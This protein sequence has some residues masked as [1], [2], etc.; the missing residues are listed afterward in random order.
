MPDTPNINIQNG[1]V[2]GTLAT[3]QPFYWYN[4]TTVTVTVKNCGTWCDRDSY[5]CAPGYTLAGMLAMPNTNPWA[6]TENPNQW[7]TPGMPHI[8]N[9]PALACPEEG[10][11]ERDVA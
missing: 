7:N 9:P 4:P 11:Q 3:G 5:M 10:D 8:T 6:W 1:D 2:T